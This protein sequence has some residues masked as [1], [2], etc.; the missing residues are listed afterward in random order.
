MTI[1]SECF[2]PAIAGYH[3]GGFIEVDDIPLI[4]MGD[5]TITQVIQEKVNIALLRY[6]G[7]KIAPGEK[8][9]HATAN[10]ISDTAKLR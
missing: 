6:K 4:I 2:I 1:A 8:I 7:G 5:D 3:F 9:S 10:L